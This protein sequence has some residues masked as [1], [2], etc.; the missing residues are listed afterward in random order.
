MSALVERSDEDFV[1][2]YVGGDKRLHHVDLS[3]F[4]DALQRAKGN[5]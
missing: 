1:F 3:R 4:V 2:V 5:L